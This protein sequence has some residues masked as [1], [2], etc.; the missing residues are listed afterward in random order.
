M[1]SVQEIVNEIRKITK[2]KYSDNLIR[3]YLHITECYERER[4]NKEYEKILVEK[5]VEQL[6]RSNS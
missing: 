2:K 4:M 3:D 5:T 6:L 1:V